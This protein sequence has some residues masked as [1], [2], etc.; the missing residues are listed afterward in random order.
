MPRTY[1]RRKSSG[2]KPTAKVH[3]GPRGGQYVLQGGRKR[4]LSGGKPKK[5]KE[6]KISDPPGS[7][8]RPGPATRCMFGHRQ[9]RL[10]KEGKWVCKKNRHMREMNHYT[11]EDFERLSDLHF[12]EGKLKN[13][14]G[15]KGEERRKALDAVRKEMEEIMDRWSVDEIRNMPRHHGRGY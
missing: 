7:R 11:A 12:M 15:L 1:S 4:Y 9:R 8:C 6:T 14:K 3:T 10:S 2:K 5:C 13:K